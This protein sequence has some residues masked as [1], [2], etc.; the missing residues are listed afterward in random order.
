[1]IEDKFQNLR[2]ILLTTNI[3]NGIYAKVLRI[4]GYGSVQSRDLQYENKVKFMVFKNLY[5]HY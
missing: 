1:M 4:G 5:K 2:I 3:T